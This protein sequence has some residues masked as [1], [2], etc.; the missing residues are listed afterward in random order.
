MRGNKYSQVV[1]GYR[2]GHFLFRM[3]MILNYWSAGYLL[4]PSNYSEVTHYCTQVF[5]QFVFIAPLAGL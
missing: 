5:E 2:P 3:V 4:C 1:N